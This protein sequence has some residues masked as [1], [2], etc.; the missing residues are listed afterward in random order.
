VGTSEK[1]E[2]WCWRGM[3]KIGWAYRVRNEEVMQRVKQDRDNL[4]IIK[5]R[6]AIWIGHILHVKFLL[7]YVIKGKIEGW[8]DVTGRRG[9]K[10][11]QLLDDLKEKRG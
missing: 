11:E 1:F 5:R 10:R 3:E 8:I 4:H 7:K 2:M 6:R 9:R